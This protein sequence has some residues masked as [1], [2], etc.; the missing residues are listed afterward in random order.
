[1]RAIGSSC[2]GKI[3]EVSHIGGPFDVYNERV[4]GIGIPDSPIFRIGL[5]M[6]KPNLD[7]CLE[8]LEEKGPDGEAQGGWDNP[9]PLPHLS[10]CQVSGHP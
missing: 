6:E 2:I 4:M 3:T 1:M 10:W 7:M 8:I 5:A 9:H